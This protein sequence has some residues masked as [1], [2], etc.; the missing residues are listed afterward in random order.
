MQIIDSVS[1]YVSLKLSVAYVTESVK[2][3]REEPKPKKPIF[4]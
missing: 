1:D 4:R 2:Q 3:P